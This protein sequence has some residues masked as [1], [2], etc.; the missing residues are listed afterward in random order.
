M[1]SRDSRDD[2]VPVLAALVSEMLTGALIGALAGLWAMLRPHAREEGVAIVL[3]SAAIGSVTFAF[4]FLLAD[5]S[6]RSRG[7]YYGIWSLATALAVV[8]D[9]IPY[10][11]EQGSGLLGLLITLAFGG[12]AGLMC[13]RMAESW[14][15]ESRDA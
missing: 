8:L 12:V 6:S 10:I 11:V 7:W 2:T 15:K 3:H 1:D 14:R 9:R 13:A 4:R 5:L